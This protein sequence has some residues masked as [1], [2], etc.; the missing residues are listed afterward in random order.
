MAEEEKDKEAW[1]ENIIMCSLPE[2]SDISFEGRQK[3]D[4]SLVMSVIGDFQSY[5]STMNEKQT[6][7]RV[8]MSSH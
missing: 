8:Q 1:S 4:K 6:L 7:H 2:S 3:H 5:L